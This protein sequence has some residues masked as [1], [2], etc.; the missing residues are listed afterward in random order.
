MGFITELEQNIAHAWS[1][2][3]RRD[4]IQNRLWK[5]ERA[6]YVSLG[7]YLRPWLDLY[8]NIRAW[9]EVK[10][11]YPES[12]G[13]LKTK[14]VDIVIVKLKEEY[15]DRLYLSIDKLPLDDLL[16]CEVKYSGE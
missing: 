13:K 5:G 3:V 2:G 9:F 15:E 14:D 10:K 7:R 12:T 6:V 1:H 4:Y 11:S 8:P 16:F